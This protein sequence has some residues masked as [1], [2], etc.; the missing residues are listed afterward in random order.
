[1]S[2]TSPILVGC[3]VSHRQSISVERALELATAHAPGTP[4]VARA[5]LH[6][7]RG[8]IL[9]EPL[10]AAHPV[11][12]F[13]NA[14]MDGFA[15]ARHDLEQAMTIGLPLD[16][17]ILAGSAPRVMRKGMACP[18]TTGAPIPQGADVVVEQERCHLREGR[19]V[20]HTAPS[21][22]PHIRGVGED[23]AE[24]ALLAP[25][26][27]IVTPRLAAVA[28][29][30]GTAQASVRAPLRIALVSTGDEIVTAGA[31]LHPGQ[32]HDSV[33]SFLSMELQH[34]SLRLID[35]GVQPDQT[36]RVAETL[37][38][39]AACADLVLTTGGASVG[40][41]D[42]VGA[43]LGIA[44]AEEIFQGVKMRPGKPL[45][46][47]LLNG[48]P[49][50]T[51]PGNPFAAAVGY[52]LVVRRMIET[53]LGAAIFSCETRPARLSANTR[54]RSG[55][56]EFV[57][58]SLAMDRSGGTPFATIISRGSSASLS[59]LAAADGIAMLSGPDAMLHAGLEVPVL[60]FGS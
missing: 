50:V 38:E 7:L 48:V 10:V 53:A 18:I 23:V 19:V 14:A 3:A 22:K 41:A 36:E 5:P 55:N 32:I 54:I 12:P 47:H 2:F 52:Y 51:L 30:S 49:V 24:G 58:I 34:P 29:A 26:G 28:S 56:A 31:P 15:L 44:G 60:K 8:R 17:P 1:M 9:A 43:A 39:A 11:P 45:G 21:A 42:P 13:A 27:R 16:A 33:R 6:S 20:L 25:A 57:P 4:L 35:L 37:Q 40:R 46:L 59:P